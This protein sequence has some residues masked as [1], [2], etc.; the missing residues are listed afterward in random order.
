MSTLA[1]PT[2]VAAAHELKEPLALIRLYAQLLAD[3]QL[4]ASE[5][6]RFER[7]IGLAAEQLLELTSG[8]VEGYRWQQQTLPLEPVAA[9]LLCEEVTHAVFE[10]AR[11]H[12]HQLEYRPRAGRHVAV[13]HRAFLRNVLYNLLCNAI[14]HSPP[15]STV[16]LRT[17]R[18]GE[19]LQLQVCDT[20]PGFNRQAL[21]ALAAGEQ[22]RQ[23]LTG[24][25]GGLGLLVAQ[26]LV[27]AMYGQLRVVASRRGGRV[28]VHLP[29]SRQLSFLS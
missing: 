22:W 18:T 10:Y 27:R 16:V 1:Q 26:E 28:D 23:P 21:A 7:R 29:L 13:A 2:L 17:G 9:N 12:G 6:R 5:R 19:H 3:H 4:D 11:Q 25:A 15:G 8:L 20:G 24:R 14:K